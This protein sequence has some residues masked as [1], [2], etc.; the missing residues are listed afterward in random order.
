MTLTVD[1]QRD[2]LSGT[3]LDEIRDLDGAIIFQGPGTYQANRI[4]VAA[5]P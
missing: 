4:A 2:R 3:L 1:R 5:R